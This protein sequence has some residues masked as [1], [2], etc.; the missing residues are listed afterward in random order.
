MRTLVVIAL[1]MGAWCWL[2]TQEPAE[3]QT[4]QEPNRRWTQAGPA[5]DVNF[6]LA[7]C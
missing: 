2:R 4:S 5:Q 6:Y 1:L 3:E 7:H